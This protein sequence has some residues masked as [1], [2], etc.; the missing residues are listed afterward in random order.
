M[1]ILQKAAIILSLFAILSANAQQI[2]VV[3][4]DKE[5]W[6]RI[7]RLPVTE[8]E[9]NKEISVILSDHFSAI[10]IASEDSILL[11]M[12]LILLY[13]EEAT[14]SPSSKKGQAFQ[15]KTGQVLELQDSKKI[16]KIK[17][18]F[19]AKENEKYPNIELDIWG[20]KD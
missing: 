18:G 3:I 4:S 2:A 14:E 16:D 6:H 12:Q 5:G 9:R 13:S 11:N 8:T 19:K 10:K 15:I 1:K 20:R 7:K 17:F